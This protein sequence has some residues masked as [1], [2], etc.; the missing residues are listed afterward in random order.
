MPVLGFAALETGEHF[1]AGGSLGKKA[2]HALLGSLGAGTGCY[3]HRNHQK[4]GLK[5]SVHP[6]LRSRQELP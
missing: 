1:F 2:N 3:F 4:P 5:G 6:F